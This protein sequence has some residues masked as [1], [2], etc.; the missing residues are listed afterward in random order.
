MF[1]SC[2]LI[3][4]NILSEQFPELHNTRETENIKPQY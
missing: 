4:E 1:L 2:R 3:M